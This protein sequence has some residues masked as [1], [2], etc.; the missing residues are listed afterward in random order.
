LYLLSYRL[1]ILQLTAGHNDVSTSL[2]QTQSLCMTNAASTTNH[3]GNLAC[4]IK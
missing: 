4:Q 2:R 1:K 3:Y